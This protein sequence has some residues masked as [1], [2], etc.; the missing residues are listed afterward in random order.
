M[1][2]RRVVGD[3]MRP[4]LLPGNIVVARPKSAVLPGQVVIARQGEREVIKRVASLHADGTVS[5]EGD[6]P[7]MSTDS[8]HLGVVKKSDILGVVIMKLKFA[9]ATPAPQ[10]TNRALL[11][12]PYLLAALTTVMLLGQLLSF[13]RFVPVIG[14][15]FL[16]GSDFVTR[17]AAAS[18][19][20]SELFALPFWLRMNLSP[21]ARVASMVSGFVFVA[22]WTFLGVWALVNNL[23][24]ANCGC[25]G[26]FLPQPFG[27]WVLLENTVLLGLIAWA[28]YILNA[29]QVLAARR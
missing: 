25:F 20:L 8:R 12:V 24:L 18:I 1:I 5:L 3:S 19:V 16:P 6:N 27:W 13:E 11:W 29:R 9:K 23:T 15:Y 22:I 4:A 26:A 28:A 10:P 14:S 2:I 21:L 17:L 7:T